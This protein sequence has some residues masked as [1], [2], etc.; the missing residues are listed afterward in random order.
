MEGERTRPWLEEV[1]QM[2]EV[3][4]DSEI[5]I[6]LAWRFYFLVGLEHLRGALQDVVYMG[7]VL[8]YL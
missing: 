5:V 1:A 7:T 2:R 3:V 4:K 8:Y 6:S